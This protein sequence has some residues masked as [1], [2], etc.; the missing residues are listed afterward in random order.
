M[1]I[2]KIVVILPRFRGSKSGICGADLGRII[3]RDRRMEIEFAIFRSFPPRLENDFEFILQLFSSQELWVRWKRG[4]T[5]GLS[6]EDFTT[7]GRLPLVFVP[8]RYV[9]RSFAIK[10]ATLACLLSGVGTAAWH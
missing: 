1:E 3:Y 8:E 4:V 6:F 10:T 7:G 5:D 9:A 2:A